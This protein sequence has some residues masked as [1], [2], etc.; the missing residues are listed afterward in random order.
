M[1]VPAN[2]HYNN[3][4]T[5]KA[6]TLPR[7]ELLRHLPYMDRALHLAA[8][9]APHA[10]PN[11]MVGAVIAAPDGR[12]IGEGFHRR[13]GGPHAEVN[14]F[15]S[16]SPEDEHLIPESTIY[17]TLEPC[18]HYGKTP[19]CARLLAEKGIKRAVIGITDP[20]P[21]VDGGGC[22]ILQEAGI[23]II[24]GV[25][26]KECE[27]I[28]RRFL[29]AQRERRPWIELKWAE[30]ADGMMGAPEGKPR[31]IISSPTGMV[32]MHRERS[33]ADA[34]L[35]GTGTLLADNPSLSLRLWPGKSPRQVIFDSPRL[36]GKALKVMESDPV[37]LDPRLPLEENMGRLFSEYGITSLLV[38]GG[39]TLLESFLSRGLYD[40]IRVERGSGRIPGGVPAPS[41]LT[42]KKTKIG[43]TI[44]S[45]TSSFAD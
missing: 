15:R 6:D 2:P 27:E 17:V 8:M 26:E 10:S 33:L 3:V 28:N 13:Y 14:A 42:L 36:Q 40:E 35:V 21:K 22:R 4:M 25:R 5:R 34:I 18:A 38:E 31:A 11:P 29:T 23:D 43:K 19:P 24:I 41:L 16:V 44:P 32:L 45:D 20:N 12:I 37:I 9:G 30:S 39:P 7:E 1:E